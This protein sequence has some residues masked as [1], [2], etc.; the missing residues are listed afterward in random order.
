VARWSGQRCCA[1]R[2]GNRGIT[3]RTGCAFAFR[4]GVE[5]ANV[6]DFAGGYATAVM[7]SCDIDLQASRRAK[8]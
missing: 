2:A 6:S 1:T 7:G 3:Q 4:S 8:W 5:I